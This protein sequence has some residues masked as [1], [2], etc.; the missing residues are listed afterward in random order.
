ME[1]YLEVELGVDYP[2]AGR[3]LFLHPDGKAYPFP[4][5]GRGPASSLRIGVSNQTG[6]AGQNVK[7][8]PVGIV[9]GLTG[10]V[11]KRRYEVSFSS[12]QTVTNAIQSISGGRSAML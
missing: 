4:P 9:K 1:N 11:P 3:P 7:A 2:V 12:I 5:T 8:Y 6:T 10:I